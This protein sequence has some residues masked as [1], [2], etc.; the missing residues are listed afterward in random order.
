KESVDELGIPL[1][2]IH[3]VF[4]WWRPDVLK[5]LLLLR[6]A[7]RTQCTSES[8]KAFFKLTLAGVLVPDLTNVTLGRLQLHFINRDH[9]VIYVWRTFK[10]HADTMLRDL[11]E[12]QRQQD[13]A[14]AV[15]FLADSTSPPNH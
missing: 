3:N 7:I 8:A 12:V 5:D 1:P 13:T 10:A 9:D 11:A 2:P 14:D 6:E 15:I 4:R